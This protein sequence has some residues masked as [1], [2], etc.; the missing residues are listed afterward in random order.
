MLR[1]RGEDHFVLL[2][3]S[4]SMTD[5]LWGYAA[6]NIFGRRVGCGRGAADFGG[7]FPSGEGGAAGDQAG[8]AF[9]GHVGPGPLD[10]NYQA[11][12]ETD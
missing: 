8:A 3:A 2:G 12:A 11:V 1:L 4:L 9:V 10:E 7:W 6:V 5:F